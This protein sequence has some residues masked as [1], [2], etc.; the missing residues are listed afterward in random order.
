MII[1][2][3]KNQPIKE[4]IFEVSFVF[5]EEDTEK[6]AD[7]D[8]DEVLDNS[9]E[10]SKDISL[11]YWPAQ[12]DQQGIQPIIIS[13]VYED[14]STSLYYL[15]VP[16]AFAGDVA[17]EVSLFTLRLTLCLMSSGNVCE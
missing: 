5:D 12:I 14:N 13:G 8:N 4:R 10:G 6:D 7:A 3:N 2:F 1:N 9:T 17:Y 16:L 15:M 11:I